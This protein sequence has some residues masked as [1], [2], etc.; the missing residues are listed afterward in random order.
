M[1]SAEVAGEAGSSPGGGIGRGEDSGVP[2]RGQARGVIARDA[3]ATNK[4]NIEHGAFP[5][6]L[7]RTG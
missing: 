3:A 2:E 7:F 1:F 4:T 5:S 6:L